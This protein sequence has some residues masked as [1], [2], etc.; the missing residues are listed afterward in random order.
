MYEV[1]FWVAVWISQYCLLPS[2]LISKY[3]D[4]SFQS[5]STAFCSSTGSD[6]IVYSIASSVSEPWNLFSF[7]FHRN[8]KSVPPILGFDIIILISNSN[9]YKGHSNLNCGVVTNS[10]WNLNGLPQPKF[11]SYVRKV[12]C[13]LGNSSRYLNFMDWVIQS[14]GFYLM[15]PPCCCYL[16]LQTQRHPTWPMTPP[17]LTQSI[18]PMFDVPISNLYVPV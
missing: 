7:S 14:S 8:I 15:T 6:L 9:F 17:S 13:V 18:K 1:R 4:F 3:A 12:H 2:L 11:I 16:S 5:P 10:P